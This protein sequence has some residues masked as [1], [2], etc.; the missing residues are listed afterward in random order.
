MEGLLGTLVNRSIKIAVS[1]FEGAGKV[2]G[3]YFSACWSPTCRDFTTVLAKWYNQQK[4]GPNRDN[5]EIIFV[6]FNQDEK[7]F[8]EYFATMPW[9]SVEFE[10][11]ERMN[12]QA[13]IGVSDIPALVFI[14]AENKAVKTKNGLN[15]VR[16]G[17]SIADVIAM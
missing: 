3:L 13:K 2:I 1:E 8:K 14:S 11:H 5:F 15:V 7:N 4:K 17:Q 10:S 16:S 12:L 9:P 6:S